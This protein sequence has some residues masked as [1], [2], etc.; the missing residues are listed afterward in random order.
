MM[1]KGVGGESLGRGYL[2][3]VRREERLCGDDME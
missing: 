1:E 2:R 3:V